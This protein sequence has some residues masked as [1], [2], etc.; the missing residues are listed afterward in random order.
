MLAY[1]SGEA[2]IRQNLV[3]VED[4]GA[5]VRLP[6]E[7][8]AFGNFIISPDERRLGAEVSDPVE[9]DQIYVF[10]VDRPQGTRLTYEGV[11]RNPVWSPDGQYLYFASDRRGD[12][13]VWRRRVD[14]SGEP[15]LVYGGDG[16]EAPAAVFPDGSGMIFVA[17]SPRNN[18]IWQ[19]DFEEGAAPQ[20]VATTE[21]DEHMPGL[22]PGGEM[23]VYHTLTGTGGV[24]NVFDIG[25]GR[26][27]R[28]GEGWGA[29][30]S[31]DGSRIF[32]NSGT[33]LDGILRVEVTSFDPF[34]WGPAAPVASNS[35]TR[36]FDV[37][38]RGAR[39]LV[40]REEGQEGAR[41]A[42][43]VT[44]NWFEELRRRVPLSPKTP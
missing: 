35:G 30:W 3:W 4:D 29:V 1:V 37:D 22:S 40:A 21:F 32:F 9:G 14:F 28:I 33:G 39:I 41:V 42:I 24:I 44:L 19:L 15:E 38:E 8:Q 13:D 26:R 34:E 25:T 18:D 16:D 10:D 11:N 20:P 12:F 6:V 17:M 43:A 23:V 31:R 5:E 27:F 36:R 2:L 7:P